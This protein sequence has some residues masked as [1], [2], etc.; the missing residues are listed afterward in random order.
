M[1]WE[2]QTS[3]L[4]SRGCLQT[5]ASMS[6]LYKNTQG[7][8]PPRPIISTIGTDIQPRKIPGRPAEVVPG[9][10]SRSS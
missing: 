3:V 4:N 8:N 2:K 6:G 5:T 10:L 7:L 9:K 1:K